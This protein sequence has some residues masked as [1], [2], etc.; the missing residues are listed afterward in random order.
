MKK[1]LIPLLLLI[2]VACLPPS[3][4]APAA[5]QTSEVLK[6]SE[7]SLTFTPSPPPTLT[8]TAT[9][10][11]TPA[12][13]LPADFPPELAAELK[14]KDY[15]IVD[16][17]IFVTG[18]DGQPH[19]YFEFYQ[20]LGDWYYSQEY[21]ENA[22]TIAG[23][24]RE[25]T[26]PENDYTMRNHERQ[27][28]G[29]F[30]NPDMTRMFTRTDLAGQSYEVECTRIAFYDKNTG[31]IR[32]AWVALTTMDNGNKIQLMEFGENITRNKAYRMKIL[33]AATAA[34]EAFT[35]ESA[36]TFYYKYN[37]IFFPFQKEGDFFNLM[38]KGETMTWSKDTIFPVISLL[39][40]FYK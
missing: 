32:I 29:I 19:A 31:A 11:L 37:L 24:T 18:A 33:V 39:S 2:L 25:N 27:F 23:I 1:I 22:M 20:D 16:N 5:R 14:D 30:P 21:L 17:H 26:Y 10:T 36:P 38:L 4:G 12:P 7:V 13:S 9:I 15:T 35:K 34:Q 3:G 40:A 6:T 8:P 28:H